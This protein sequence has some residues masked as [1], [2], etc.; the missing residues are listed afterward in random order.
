M[1]TVSPHSCRKQAWGGLDKKG[2]IIFN[3]ESYL[4]SG[5]HWSFILH[6]KQ[7]PFF[8]LWR[9]QCWRGGP[10]RPEQGPLSE[11]RNTKKGK[12]YEW[13]CSHIY[14]LWSNSPPPSCV[15]VLLLW[16]GSETALQL[17]DELP[18]VDKTCRKM[19]KPKLHAVLRKAKANQQNLWSEHTLI[20]ICQWCNSLVL[21]DNQSTAKKG[22]CI[23]ES[24]YSPDCPQHLCIDR[25]L[26][27]SWGTWASPFPLC[28]K[29]HFLCFQSLRSVTSWRQLH[30]KLVWE[31]LELPWE[32]THL[33][34]VAKFTL[35]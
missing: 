29:G 31:Q 35:G 1:R 16:C 7:N 24:E 19:V 3:W 22:H 25:F 5:D 11:R 34:C 20:K 12:P 33:W 27:Y 17:P 15:L 26:A 2:W 30:P 8:P 13:T 9:Q 21:R 32:E 23:R 4:S 14:V 6:L 18:R 10:R 28:L